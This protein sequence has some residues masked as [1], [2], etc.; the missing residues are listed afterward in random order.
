[1]AE[2]IEALAGFSIPRLTKTETTQITPWNTDSGL[3]G[4][5]HITRSTH[6]VVKI[7]Q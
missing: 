5:G 3:R 4:I 1:M 2:V 6:G 7:R